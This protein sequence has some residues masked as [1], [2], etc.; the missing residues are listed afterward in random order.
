M[1]AFLASLAGLFGAVLGY[2]LATALSYPILVAVEGRDMEGGLAMGAA[3]VIGPIG[4]ITGAVL[5][6][7]LVLRARRD[8][9]GESLGKQG[10]VAFGVMVALFAGLYGYLFHEPAAPSFGAHEP[11]PILAFELRVPAGAVLDD[12]TFVP[13]AQVA[14][15]N[16][17]IRTSGRMTM[18]RDGDTAYFTAKVPLYFKIDTRRL[19]VWLGRHTL[20]GFDLPIAKVPAAEA[21]F[22]D[23]RR[24]NRIEYRR[25]GR[26]VTDPPDAAFFIRTRVIWPQ[27]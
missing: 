11:K 5:G 12:G 19:E 14:T 4:A 25:E 22:G 20:Y 24:V 3:L 18:R 1:T 16:T 2:G 21:R 6:V 26:T 9:P 7:W 27:R 15:Y 23:W 17:F 13:W 10:L 8:R